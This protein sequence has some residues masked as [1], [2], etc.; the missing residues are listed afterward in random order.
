MTDSSIITTFSD[1]GWGEKKRVFYF[2]E[3]H[4]QSICIFFEIKG[5]LFN[6]GECKNYLDKLD[7]LGGNTTAPPRMCAIY[8]HNIV[9]IYLYYYIIYIILCTHI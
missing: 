7:L 2:G 3:G 4:N 6:W 9:Y 8:A 5:R 1:R